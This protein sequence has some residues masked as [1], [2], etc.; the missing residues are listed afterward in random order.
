MTHPTVGIACFSTFGGSGVVA[1]EIAMALA[2]RGH[3]VHVFSD[4]VPGRLDQRQPNV[5]FHAVEVR[6]YPQLKHP[7]YTLALS[8]K[9]IEVARR[10]RL[11][12]IHAHYAIPH[13]ASAYL[14][15]QVLAADGLTSAPRLVTTLHGTDITLIGSDDSF[16]PLMQFAIA[17]SE[18]V[19]TPSHWLREATFT[20]LNVPRAMTID[21]IPNFVDT[22]RFAPAVAGRAR[23]N[24]R[25]MV[26]VSNFRPVKRLDDVLAVF[27]RVRALSPGSRTVLQL[28]GDGPER[29]RIMS[30]VHA[31]GLEGDVQ[32]LGE[33]VDLPDILR[34]AD[35]FLLPSETES[36]GLAALEAMACGVPVVASAT[37]GLPEVVIDGETGVLRPVGDVG[38]MA[39]AVLDLLG[40]D[41]RAARMARAA[42]RRAEEHFAPGPA[43]D[44]YLDLYR[45]VLG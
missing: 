11:D 23:S 16:L 12:L 14:A 8:S 7:P 32:H 15:R 1:A 5:L 10:E 9:L 37:G 18:A 39:A 38:G 41:A 44:R 3:R 33:R 28:V 13:A 29:P 45:R 30:L 31:M 42:R 26:H 34:G 21:V 6:A 19:T 36:F 22:D 2:H 24:S 35:V 17:S 40:D 43:I 25:V 27:A 4:D 20:R